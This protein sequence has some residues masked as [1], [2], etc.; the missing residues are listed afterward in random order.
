MPRVCRPR[1]IG[2][3]ARFGLEGDCG[4]SS[5]PGGHTAA[6]EMDAGV[7]RGDEQGRERADLRRGV[8]EA[9]PGDPRRSTS[10][11][12]HV[13]MRT[14]TASMPGSN[15]AVLSHGATH[16]TRAR[17]WRGFNTRFPQKR[18][19]LCKVSPGTSPKSTIGPQT[20]TAPRRSRFWGWSVRMPHGSSSR[21]TAWRLRPRNRA[22]HRRFDLAERRARTRVPQRA[23]VRPARI[24]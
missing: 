19:E 4:S 3:R 8:Q 23:C 7:H 10:A 6:T 14:P 17:W 12:K 1:G 20:M 15:P 5:A 21:T 16:A 18:I 24:R 2:G 22:F 13:P 11:S 9:M